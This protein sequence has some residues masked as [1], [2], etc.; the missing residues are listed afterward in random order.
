MDRTKGRTCS[1]P[2]GWSLAARWAI[3]FT[4]VAAVLTLVLAS[5]ALASS[6]GGQPSYAP[7]QAFLGDDPLVPALPDRDSNYFAFSFDRS[8][9]DMAYV[10]LRI[11]G[12]FGHARYM[13]YNIYDADEGTSRGALADYQILPSPGNVN[14]F[15]PGV[16]PQATNRAYVIAVQPTGYSTGPE[17]NTL[18]Y[19]P[20]VIGK[21]SVFLRYY[22]PEGGRTA[23][24]PLPSIEA[25][26]V[27]T[28]ESLSLPRL[29][30]I[31]LDVSVYE[32]RLKPIFYTIIDDTLR[33]YHA[34]GLRQ[35]Q[36]ADNL[37][38]ISAVEWQKHDV[39]TFRFK[40]PKVPE[41]NSEYGDSDVRYWSIGLYNPDTTLAFSMK[42][43]QFRRAADGFI[44]VAIGGEEI[45]QK[46][47]K[48]GYNFMPWKVNGSK[49][50][51]LYRNMLSNPAYPGLMTKVPIIT[52]ENP[53]N[54]Y[55]DDAKNFIGDYAPTGARISLKDFIGE[56]RTPRD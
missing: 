56:H 25:Y 35:F 41:D 11:R 18:T 45:R 42:D 17:E 10:G 6:K 2:T 50:V 29:Y 26:D 16:D 13:S 8:G 34:V 27:R 44:Y 4:I 22:V 52:F 53:A 43:D 15:L 12:D 7:W 49:G 38:L 51:I 46:A 3:I 20:A 32:N 47:E 24:V 37:Y 39:L 9:E 1:R 30:P 14:P 33:F 23:G 40:P 36:N 48:R 54:V 19:D 5:S 21:L 31:T 55:L 28:G